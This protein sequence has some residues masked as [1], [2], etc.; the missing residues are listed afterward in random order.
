MVMLRPG[1]SGELL[2]AG[3]RIR[4]TEPGQRRR[5]VRPLRL[6]RQRPGRFLNR[7]HSWL[8]AVPGTFNG[9]AEDRVVVGQSHEPVGNL[10][11]SR[12]RWRRGAGCREIRVLNEDLERQPR[13]RR[14]PWRTP[15][16]WAAT[17]VRSQ[18]ADMMRPSSYAKGGTGA[19]RGAWLRGAR[20]E[21]LPLLAAAAVM[22]PRARAR[23][24]GDRA[25]AGNRPPSARSCGAW[26]IAARTFAFDAPS[27]D[28]EFRP[29]CRSGRRLRS[30][31]L[32]EYERTAFLGG[33]RANP[34]ATR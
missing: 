7:G 23:A 33:R 22:A 4:D 13:W 29:P 18:A 10:Q 16:S 32:D 28:G 15:S 11:D 34:T 14:T 26:T 19:N 12:H 25:A 2:A 17:R 21:R 20:R 27:A 3:D 30:L 24:G 5:S 6:R 31:R 8:S 1:H 9:E